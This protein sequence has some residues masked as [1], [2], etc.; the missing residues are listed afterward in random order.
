MRQHFTHLVSFTSRSPWLSNADVAVC[1]QLTAECDPGMLASLREALDLCTENVFKYDL[2]Y[3]N[4]R[5]AA[6]D[7]AL[8][9]APSCL[10]PAALSCTHAPK[11]RKQARFVSTVLLHEASAHAAAETF[12]YW[13]LLQDVMG[14]AP[15]AQPKVL[16]VLICRLPRSR[17][18]C[19]AQ[20][21][22]GL[23]PVAC[24][25]TF[26][27]LWTSRVCP[28]AYHATVAEW[29]GGQLGSSH[30]HHLCAGL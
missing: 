28:F 21:L 19:V 1:P 13:P 9:P 14:W 3:I 6:F 11:P 23:A 5:S 10:L 8:L 4:V 7:T 27:G 2:E 26:F 22:Q 18:L 30:R 17:Q 29:A 12:Y 16:P 15:D 24:F 25:V 20:L